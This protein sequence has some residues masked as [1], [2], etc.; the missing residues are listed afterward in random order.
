LTLIEK[1]SVDGLV[2]ARLDRLARTLTVQEAV[3]A[4]VWKHGGKVFSCDVGEVFEDDPSDPM[5]TFVRQVMGAAAQL[6]RGMIAARMRA[7]RERKAEKGGSAYGAPPTAGGLT[8]ASLGMR[9]RRGCFAE[10]KSSAPKVARC[11]PSPPNL[12]QRT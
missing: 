12:S 7:G 6:E 4:H 10:S 8:R 11:D 3:L 5:R 9:R 2:V 1:Q